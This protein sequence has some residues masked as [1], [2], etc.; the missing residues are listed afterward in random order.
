[1]MGANQFKSIVT[2]TLNAA[3][4]T[5]YFMHGLRKGYVNRVQ[6]KVSQAGGKGINVAR[7]IKRLGGEVLALGYIGGQTGQQ[8]QQMLAEEGIPSALNEV[9]IGESRECLAINDDLDGTVTE[10]TEPGIQIQ[11]SD[12][13]RLNFVLESSISKMSYVVFSGSLPPGCSVEEFHLLVQTCH[14]LGALVMIDTE[15]AILRDSLDWGLFSIK[16][17]INEF[18][19]LYPKKFIHNGDSLDFVYTNIK[20]ISNH[21][22]TLPIV[23]MGEKGAVAFYDGELYRISTPPLKKVNTVGSGDAFVAGLLYGLSC[24]FSPIE[25]LKLAGASGAANVLEPVAGVVNS[26]RVYQIMKNVNVE[27]V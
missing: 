10:I 15:G 5:T 4:D 13:E 8:I 20:T 23:T 26:E 2:V 16:P 24:G 19:E 9:S 6:W 27:I 22:I 18:E 21:G 14:K 11:E 3:I 12:I 17:N 1:M 25:S 7:V